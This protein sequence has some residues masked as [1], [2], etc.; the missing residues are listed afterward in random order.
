MSS[1]SQKYDEIGTVEIVIQTQAGS[2]SGHVLK[3]KG[4]RYKAKRL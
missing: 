3:A 4:N 1:R 2:S